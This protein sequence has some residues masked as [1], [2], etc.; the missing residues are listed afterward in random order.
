MPV[1]ER[2]QMTRDRF[3]GSYLVPDASTIGRVLARLD[4]DA[5]DTAI[6]RWLITR[7]AAGPAPGRRVIAVDGKTLR[8]SGRPGGQAHLLAALDQ[9]TGTVLAQTNV[10]GK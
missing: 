3:T 8:G 5:L 6:G 1:L 7:T 9:R 4:A 2:L 10:D